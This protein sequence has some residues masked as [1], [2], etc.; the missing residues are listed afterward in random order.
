MR[1]LTRRGFVAGALTVLSPLANRTSGLAANTNE[2][3]SDFPSA[4]DLGTIQQD[5]AA[6]LVEANPTP[7]APS[8]TAGQAIVDFALSYVG[9]PYVA[10]GNSPYGF[11]CSGFT[12]FVMLNV[13]G[14]DIGHAVEG[15]PYTGAWVEWDAWQ[16]GDVIFF[17]NTYRAGI[18]HAAIYIGDYQFVHAENESTGVTISSIWSD[19]YLSRYWGAIRLV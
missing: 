3:A 1:T 17:Q 11:D 5:L 10:G 19:Y 2:E 6:V 8:A 15:Q 16:P 7:E 14:I 9:Y 18:S 12:Q 13:L 4:T